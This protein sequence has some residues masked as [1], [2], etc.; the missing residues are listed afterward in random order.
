MAML[1][2]RAALSM[3]EAL[4]SAWEIEMC[5]LAL[6]GLSSLAQARGFAGSAQT[7]SADRRGEGRLRDKLDLVVRV[8][9]VAGDC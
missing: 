5:C 9:A 6:P 2:L 7:G 8:R 4:K 1:F 3:T